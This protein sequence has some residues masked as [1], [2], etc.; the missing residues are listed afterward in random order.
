MSFHETFQ[1]TLTD[2]GN[3]KAIELLSALLTKKFEKQG[4]KIGK[5][6]IKE[7]ANKAVGGETSISFDSPSSK[8]V[9]IIITESESERLESQLNR[10]LEKVNRKLPAVYQKTADETA[11]HTVKIL[12]RNQ[13]SHLEA[14]RRDQEKFEKKLERIWRKPFDLFEAYISVV[15]HPRRHGVAGQVAA[16]QAGCGLDARRGRHSSR[17]F[18]AVPLDDV[19]EVLFRLQGRGVQ[20]A[21]EILVLMRAG[22]SPA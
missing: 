6:K 19:F 10:W 13:K 14:V 8:E 7:L 20:I 18:R 15:V 3:E 21:R 9:E 17:T 1:K 12:M 4:L 16:G 2:A 11:E 22:L 5:R